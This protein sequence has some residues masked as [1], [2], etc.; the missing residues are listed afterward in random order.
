MSSTPERPWLGSQYQGFQKTPSLKWRIGS[1]LWLALPLFGCGC[2]GSIGLLYVGIRARKPSWWIPAIVYLVVS[3]ASFA[4]VGAAKEDTAPQNV[5]TT[6]LMVTWLVCL[7]HA[8]LINTSWLQWSFR[9]PLGPGRRRSQTTISPYPV[10][11][12]WQ[13]PGDPML[14]RLAVP[15]PGTY[16]AGSPAAPVPMPVAPVPM[17]VAGPLDVN[18]SAS[19]QLARLPGLDQA[20]AERIVAERQARGGFD[21]TAQ[22]AAAAGLAPHEFA[23]IRHLIVC[24]PRPQESPDQLPAPDSPPPHQGRILDV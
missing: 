23:R 16:Y 4:I 11:P 8:A 17:P 1:S 2:L 7:L 15:P 5:A 13:P 6:V 21:T 9:H 19:E 24:H 20:R 10:P 22:F 12:P 3:I 18:S 14:Q